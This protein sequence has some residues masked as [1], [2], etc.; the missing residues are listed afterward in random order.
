ME[1]DLRLKAEKI[2]NEIDDTDAAADARHEKMKD[3]A[4]K[5]TNSSD[6]LRITGRQWR[7][8]SPPTSRKRSKPR[9]KPTG[10]R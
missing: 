9:K 7:T 10:R 3:V 2:Q 8:S 6:A 5:A 4:K 1:E